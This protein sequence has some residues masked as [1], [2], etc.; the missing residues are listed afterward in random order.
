MLTRMRTEDECDGTLAKGG[1]V[2]MEEDTCVEEEGLLSYQST[3]RAHS[4]YTCS[5]A[6]AQKMDA[7][8]A[9]AGC[10]CGKGM[11]TESAARMLLYQTLLPCTPQGQVLRR[12]IMSHELRSISG[13]SPRCLF[14]TGG[15]SDKDNTL[16]PAASAA[17]MYSAHPSSSYEQVSSS[18]I[19]T[20][21][22][23]ASAHS[24]PA[25]GG[26]EEEGCT[27]DAEEE[28]CN[29]QLFHAAWSGEELLTMARKVSVRKSGAQ[30]QVQ[31]CGQVTSDADFG[32]ILVFLLDCVDDV[33]PGCTVRLCL[34][35]V[36][37]CVYVS[38]ATLPHSTLSLFARSPPPLM[39]THRHAQVH[40][41]MHMRVLM[42]THDTARVW[43]PV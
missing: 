19:L 43:R 14:G 34:V 42:I 6:C 23:A 38:T 9:A 11:V 7:I 32:R 15:G 5:H 29:H 20:R 12:A 39:R 28:V 18:L 30:E 31:V 21:A 16:P 36:C 27:N 26:V 35:C 33:L 24:K 4:I 13:L 37:V 2:V 22:S 1:F 25:A 41:H 17:G 40:G 10:F 3:T 8:A